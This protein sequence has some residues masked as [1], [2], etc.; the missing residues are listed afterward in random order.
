M[1]TAVT[2]NE[3]RG[4]MLPEA[5]RNLDPKARQAQRAV[6][7]GFQL[8]K[9]VGLYENHVQNIMQEMGVQNAVKLKTK[10][11]RIYSCKNLYLN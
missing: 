7:K 5:N 3:V 10:N 8:Q 9:Y 1:I 4:Y 6:R 2:M 11:P